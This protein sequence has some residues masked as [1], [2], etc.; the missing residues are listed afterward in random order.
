MLPAGTSIAGRDF[1][2][3]IQRAF[4]RRTQPVRCPHIKD[5]NY[6]LLLLIA[7]TPEHLA[8]PGSISS[9]YLPR[10]FS[11][12]RFLPSASSSPAEPR[13]KILSHVSNAPGR[14]QAFRRESDAP[15]G[16]E[17]VLPFVP[18]ANSCLPHLVLGRAVHA[19]H[20][21][22]VTGHDRHRA[23]ELAAVVEHEQARA[24]R[25]HHVL[26]PLAE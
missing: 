15:S 12:P 19:V 6:P 25:L 10:C 16:C 2:P 7:P 1:H 8:L 21:D 24:I 5:R 4:S 3:R 13:S 23:N 11:Y 17:T 22:L 26:K 20:V 18:R 9:S 14:S